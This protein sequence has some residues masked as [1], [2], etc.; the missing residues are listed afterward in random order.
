[1][2]GVSLPNLISSFPRSTTLVVLENFFC[3][4]QAGAICGW[5]VWYCQVQRPVLCMQRCHRQWVERIVVRGQFGASMQGVDMC[6]LR[7]YAQTASFVFEL[8]AWL[9]SWEREPACV[10]LLQRVRGLH[11]FRVA[12]LGCGQCSLDWLLDASM[13]LFC[14]IR[15][16]L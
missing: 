16:L 10:L 2:S 4:R 15:A 13:L 3:C 12:S 9:W 7:F 11:G 6:T 14:T 8:R 5:G 1:V